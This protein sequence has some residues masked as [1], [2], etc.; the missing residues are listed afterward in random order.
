MAES[1]G[2]GLIGSFDAD[3]ESWTS[4]T[5]RLS[6]YFVANGIADA[7]KKRAILLTACGPTTYQLM[8][9]LLAPTLPSEK[10]F[11]DLVKLVKDHQQPT[12]SFI[13]QRFHFFTRMQQPGESINDYLAQ[14]RKL[15][16]H[17]RFGDTL[18]D[19]L[20]DRLVCG[21]RDKRLQYK[22]LSDDELTYDKAIKIAKS[23]ETAEP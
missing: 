1:L 15:A 21:C 17:C 3:A 18:N 22:L 20:R 10:S 4:Y 11:K 7:A 16:Q 14:L 12:P 6:S 9:D 8:R 5:E 23:D 19:M 2:L 13:V